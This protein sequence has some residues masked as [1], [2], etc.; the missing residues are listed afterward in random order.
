MTSTTIEPSDGDN[1]VRALKEHLNAA[2]LKAAEPAIAAALLE[3]EKTMRA[4]LATRLIALV[5]TDYS[6]DRNGRDLRIT[7]R[8]AMKP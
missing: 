2:M 5:D 7:V 6:F 3:V 1:F 8:Q 4:E